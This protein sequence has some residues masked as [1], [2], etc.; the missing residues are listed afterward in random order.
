MSEADLSEIEYG[1]NT[2]DETI[3][4]GTRI[5]DGLNNLYETCTLAVIKS[6]EVG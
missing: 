5:V 4:F 1:F 3:N 6:K 2:A